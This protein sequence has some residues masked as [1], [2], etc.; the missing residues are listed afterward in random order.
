[1]SPTSIEGDVLPP[2]VKPL[3][4]SLSRDSGPFC[5]SVSVG[6]FR[7]R[8]SHVCNSSNSHSVNMHKATLNAMHNMHC[9]YIFST[10]Q[11]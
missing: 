6:I 11:Y 7:E 2:P 9:I 4:V 3:P 5:A 1:M 8:F 10:S